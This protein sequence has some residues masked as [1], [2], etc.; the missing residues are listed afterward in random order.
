MLNVWT[1][2]CGATDQWSIDP[3]HPRNPYRPKQV[4]FSDLTNSCAITL[5]DQTHE[6]LVDLILH[7]KRF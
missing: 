6:L 4:R 5:S 3:A 7:D 1:Y 2:L